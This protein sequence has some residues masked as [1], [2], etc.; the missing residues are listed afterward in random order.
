L[1]EDGTFKE[2]QIGLDDRELGLFLKGFGQ[3][4]EGELYVMASS[5]RGPLGSG[6]SIFKIVTP[7][8][9]LSITSIGISDGMVHLA[10]SGG[11]G[12][13]IVQSQA[14]L[15]DSL[16][17]DILSTAAFE[18]SVPVDGPAGFFRI[19]DEGPGAGDSFDVDSTDAVHR[20][21]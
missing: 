2:F 1:D 5:G 14:R 21:D 3:D 11:V 13:F 4:A 20:S 19:A 16:W 7:T 10:W 18:A 9:T 6:G 12:P 8:G 17:A 15:G